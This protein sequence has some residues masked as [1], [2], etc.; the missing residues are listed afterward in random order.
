MCRGV[1]VWCTSVRV[2]EQILHLYPEREASK[3]ESWPPRPG[4][5]DSSKAARVGRSS[6]SLVVAGINDIY[7][8]RLDNYK[9]KF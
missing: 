6:S 7:V 2:Q 9:I 5:C 1:S 4:D 8:G 3:K